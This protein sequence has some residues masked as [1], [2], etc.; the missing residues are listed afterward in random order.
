MN[1]NILMVKCIEC[2]HFD[3]W[4]QCNVNILLVKCNQWKYFDGQ[5]Q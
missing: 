4:M 5:M 3:D 2:K 1:V